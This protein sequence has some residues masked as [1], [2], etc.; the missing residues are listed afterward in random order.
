MCCWHCRLVD[1][2]DAAVER[3]KQA[4]QERDGYQR[5]FLASERTLKNRDGEME[6]R[7]ATSLRLMQLLRRC[8][9]LGIEEL[10]YNL[11]R[12]IGAIVEEPTL[13]SDPRERELGE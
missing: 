12:E 9:G 5:A 7:A 1:E 11:W 8:Y 4:E 6:Q 13:S 3:A 2:R 10:G